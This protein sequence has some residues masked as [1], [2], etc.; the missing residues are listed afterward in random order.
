MSTIIKLNKNSINFLVNLLVLKEN[1][2]NQLKILN[3]FTNS[4]S[5][6]LIPST[7]EIILFQHYK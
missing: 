5:E 4:N 1:V 3:I 6:S 7:I 2:G